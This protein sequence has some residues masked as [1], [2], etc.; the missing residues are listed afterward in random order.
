MWVSR[1]FRLEGSVKERVRSNAT[2]VAGPASPGL[3]HGPPTAYVPPPRFV[4]GWH[5]NW[6]SCLDEGAP[7]MLEEGSLRVRDQE[8]HWAWQWVDTALRVVLGGLRGQCGL[9]FAA[10]GFAIAEGEGFERARAW[11]RNLRRQAEAGRRLEV[12]SGGYTL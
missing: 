2:M 5:V 12:V 10:I 9:L 6:N 1:L 4:P 3:F 7:T 11:W 8:I